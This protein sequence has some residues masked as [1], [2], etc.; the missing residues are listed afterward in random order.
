MNFIRTEIADVVIIEPKI[1]QDNRGYFFESFRQ[2]LFEKFINKK[3]NFIQEN[4]SKS[5]YGVLRGLHFQKS[6]FAQ[7]KLVRVIQGSVIDI[8]VD[9]QKNSKSFK[10]YIKV[11]LS[12]KN[13]RQLFIP[14]G[15]AHGFLVTSPEVILSYKVDNYYSK[16][17]DSG[18]RYDDPLIGIDW[19]IDTNDIVLSEKDISVQTLKEWLKTPASDLF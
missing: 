13:K 4:E 19:G 9:L 10:K 16:E 12:A 3:I 8:A 17:N 2:D 5:H 1:F 6:P 14:R 11:E 15:F 18:I 7:A